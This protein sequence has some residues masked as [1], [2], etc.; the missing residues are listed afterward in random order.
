MQGYG[1]ATSNIGV[2]FR[3]EKK[4]KQALAWFER[5]VELKDRDANLEIAKIHLDKVSEAGSKS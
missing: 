5:A 1:A 2:L 4:L 3:D